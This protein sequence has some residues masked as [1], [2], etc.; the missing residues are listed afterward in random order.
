MKKIALV[1]LIGVGFFLQSCCP[2]CPSTDCPKCPDKKSRGTED[3][4]PISNCPHPFEHKLAVTLKSAST[5]PNCWALDDYTI[6][7]ELLHQ[8]D[9]NQANDSLQLHIIKW[10]QQQVPHCSTSEI[11]Y[12]IRN[13][14]LV[15]KVKTGQKDSLC[16]SQESISKTDS[17]L[18]VFDENSTHLLFSNTGTVHGNS[19]LSYRIIGEEDQRHEGVDKTYH[20]IFNI[21]TCKVAIA[22]NKNNNKSEIKMLTTSAKGACR[23]NN[24]ND[25]FRTCIEDHVSGIT[26]YKCP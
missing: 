5:F 10:N 15:F 3:P 8:G 4:F 25:C 11:V 26:N 13:N 23:A 9:N 2:E 7:F 14:P 18:F 6:K 16:I 24:Q 1:L 12:L 19:E 20:H 21:E 17:I 22:H